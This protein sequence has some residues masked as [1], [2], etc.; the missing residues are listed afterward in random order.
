MKQKVLY[1]C[2]LLCLLW[3]TAC[4][5]TDYTDSIPQRSEALLGV[6][7]KQFAQKETTASFARLLQVDDVNACGIDWESKVYGFLSPE[8]FFG[9]C[10]KVDDADAITDWLTTL[11]QK[12]TASAPIKRRGLNFA[13]WKDSWCMGWSDDALLVMGPVTPQDQPTLMNVLAKYLKQDS[14][15]GGKASPLFDKLEASKAPVAC[16]AHVN[17]LPEKFRLPFALGLSESEAEKVTV[18][19]DIHPQEGAWILEGTTS[20]ED[21]QVAGKLSTIRSQFRRLDGTFVNLRSSQ[22]FAMLMVNA[23]GKQFLP[24]LQADRSMQALLAGANTAIDM[25]NILRSVNGE[26][27]LQLF[28]AGQGGM[29]PALQARLGNAVWLKDVGYWKKSVP[30]GGS[31]TDWKPNAFLYRTGTTSFYFGVTSD[32]YFYSG[33]SEE[34]ARLA[35][36]R[37]EETSSQALARMV[38][39]ARLAMLVNLKAGKNNTIAPLI[40][41]LEP[42][43]GTRNMIVYT[44]K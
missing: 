11:A 20:S 7:F 6:N 27:A 35:E 13:V 37:K 9:L 23:D 38:R 25:D 22:P 40:K 28:D 31:L 42:I 41:F 26:M 19:V 14:D 10:A 33:F 8:G 30:Q 43:I 32:K 17:A 15:M 1:G 16:V 44:W 4:S 18:S 5:Q 12:G 3:C 29:L 21:K 24:L 36:A 39:G 2:I 34:S